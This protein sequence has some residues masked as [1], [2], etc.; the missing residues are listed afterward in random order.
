MREKVAVIG[1]GQTPFC[2]VDTQKT[3]VEHV[4][5]AAKAALD[6]AGLTPDGIDAIAIAFLHAWKYPEHEQRVAK[7]VREMGFAQVSVSHEVSRLS[8]N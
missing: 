4:Q 5:L 1:T 2:S 3:Y 7:L 8:E 6:D